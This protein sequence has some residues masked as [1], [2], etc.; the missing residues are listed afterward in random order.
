VDGVLIHHGDVP[1]DGV[2]VIPLRRIPDQRGT[3]YRMLRATDPY[4]VQFGEI[5]FSTVYPGV[6]KA[7]KRHHRVTLNYACISGLVKVV[8]YDDRTDLPT[9]GVVMEVFLGPDSYSLVV[10]PPGVWSGF[11][12][13]SQPLAMIANCATEPNDQTEFDRIDPRSELIPYTW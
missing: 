1:I 6:V 2:R 8:L 7:W 12:G 5:Y 3:V 9:S 4:F 10:I 13:I 11:Q